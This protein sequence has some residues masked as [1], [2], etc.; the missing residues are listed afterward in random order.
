[1]GGD[2]MQEGLARLGAPVALTFMMA[3]FGCSLRSD[4]TN[5]SVDALQKGDGSAGTAGA[6]AAAGP[7]AAASVTTLSESKSL[8]S[9]SLAEA[10]QLCNDTY[11]YYGRSISQAVL[12]KEAG[13]AYGVSSSSPTDAQLRENCTKQEA[14]CLASAVAVPICNSIPMSCSVTVAQYS[15]CIADQVAAFNAGVTPLVSCSAVTQN[16]LQSIWDFVTKETPVSCGLLTNTCA[17]LDAPTP[18]PGTNGA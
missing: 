2:V 18:H 4:S 9:L 15:T 8:R 3:A 1:M 17:G 6:S 10:A 12:C 5:N 11:A 14:D 13:L 16:D 7:G